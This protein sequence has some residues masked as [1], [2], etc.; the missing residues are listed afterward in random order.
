MPVQTLDPAALPRSDIYAQL[1]VATGTRLVHL[2]GQVARTAAG[3]PVGAGDLACQTAQAFRNVAAALDAAGATFD[4]VAK[5]TV[6]VVD[7]SPD[8]MAQLG[9]GLQRV[10]GELR[11]DPRRPI[12]LI[13]VSALGEP[14]M[15][16][17]IEAVAVLA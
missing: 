15:L 8:K 1:S 13:G 12:T 2:S 5:L 3:E 9:E 11:G 6:Y 10:A 14:D 16:V 4:D 7:Y 17:E